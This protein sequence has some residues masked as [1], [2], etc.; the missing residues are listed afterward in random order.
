MFSI[1]V[2]VAEI[3]TEGFYSTLNEG[4]FKQNA[5][6]REKMG[7]RNNSNGVIFPLSANSLK[8]FLSKRLTL[9]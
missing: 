4:K 8:L 7:H 2:L 6:E 9:I 3:P 5:K 1:E